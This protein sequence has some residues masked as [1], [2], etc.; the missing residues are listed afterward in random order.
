VEVAGLSGWAATRSVE[1]RWMALERLG[2]G[3]FGVL[4]IGG[5]IVGARVAYDAA[6]AGLRVALVDAGDFAGATSGA[7]A[8]LMHGGLRYLKRGD[9]ALV[10]AA[11]RERNAF[12]SRI[13][14]HLVTP[15]PFVAACGG[16]V[17]RKVELAAGLSIYAAT[18]GLEWPVPRPVSR[19]KAAALAAHLSPEGVAPLAVLHEAAVDDAR[20]TLATVKAA[21]RAGAVVVNHLGVRELRVVAGGVSEAVMSGEDGEFRVRTRAV[22]N[23]TGPWTDA[24][25]RMEDPRCGPVTRLSKG[26]HVALDAGEGWRAGL[27]VFLGDGGHLYAIPRDGVLVLGT[28]DEAFAG[29]PGTV[30][31]TPGDVSALLD[32][33]SAFLPDVV[34]DGAVLSAYAGLRVLPRSGGGTADAP[35]G[36]LLRVGSG[37]MVSVAGGKLTTHR[38][39]SLDAI[40]HLPA[41]IRPR[42]IRPDG[43]PLPGSFGPGAGP[44][45]PRADTVG[46]HLVRVYGAEAG[47]VIS[48][49]GGSPNALEPMAP[50][51]PD[52]W[53][54]GYYAVSEEW[55]VTVEDVVRRRTALALRGLD[56]PGVRAR[57]SAA[58]GL[59][60]Y[61]PFSAGRTA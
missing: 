3:V 34:R 13:A 41:G 60:D 30:T 52:V 38:G 18:G 20:L 5:G 19:Q 29:D 51:G 61:S 46:R 10:R 12:A 35:R 47:T 8:G 2:S 22:V 25:R 50:G 31:A 58:L 57:I 48:Y 28:T 14:P 23:A 49:S 43:S 36:H 1:P 24:V 9:V 44:V 56:T 17:T 6:R 21:A 54:Q 26:I 45:P 4:V 55:A 59:P 15:L 11:C 33:V 16:G 39:I 37:G 40:R 42:K 32:R 53:V 27:A 7:S